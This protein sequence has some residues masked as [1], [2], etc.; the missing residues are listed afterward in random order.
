MSSGNNETI[1]VLVI[2]DETSVA[3]A[4]A[5]ILGDSGYEVAVF[6][7]G[8][9]GIDHARK[10][11][12]DVA[13][14]DFR[15]P[16]MSGLEV[17]SRVLQVQPECVVIVISAYSAPE[18]VAACLERGAVEVLSNPFFPSDVLNLITKSLAGRRTRAG[19]SSPG[20]TP[21]DPSHE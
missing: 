6:P 13:I 14:T 15:L 10:Q 1:K 2:D 16:D 12:F 21:P 5:V 9:E 8:R 4:L 18:I 17:V 19:C 11:R 3:D 7:N 20:P